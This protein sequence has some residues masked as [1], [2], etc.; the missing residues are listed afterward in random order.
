MIDKK[1]DPSKANELEEKIIGHMRLCAQYADM[2]QQ[3][4]SIYDSG[5][6][7]ILT[8]KFLEHARDCSKALKEL[9]QLRG[10]LD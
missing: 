9:R 1:S 10:V 6:L 7:I 2:S 4:S 8:D 3:A 5:L